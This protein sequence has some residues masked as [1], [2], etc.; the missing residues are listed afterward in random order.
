MTTTDN[1]AASDS[2]P[3]ALEDAVTTTDPVV[4]GRVWGFGGM[5]SV[6]L[7]AFA[8]FL[9]GVERLDLASAGV[10]D[11]ADGLF[12]FWSAYRVAFVLLGVLPALMALATTVVPRQCGGSLVFPRAAALAC[13]TWVVGA[14][15]T[16]VGFLVDGGLGTPGGGGER[17]ATAL[18]LMG[19]LLVICG[20][21]LAS[22]C[23]MTTIV[24]GRAAGTGLRDLPFTAW[25]TLVGAT[26]WTGM[27]P[28]LAANAVLAYVD[29]RG[30]PAVRFGAEDAIW[31]QLSWMF[32]H[33]AIY[34]LALP[35]LGIALDLVSSTTRTAQ[36]NRDV[37]LVATA[38]FGFL[39]FGAFAQTFFD[40]PGTPI[41]EEAISVVA[42]FAIVPVTLAIVG[43]L[44]DTLRRGA[45]NLGP[46]PP[47]EAVCSILAA[48]L[49]LAATVVGAVRVIAPLELLDTSVTGAHFALL[50]GAVIL[51]LGA[52]FHHWGE[53]LVGPEGRRPGMFLLGGL[54][55]AG[56]TALV[57]AADLVS[58]LM[59]Q[60][61]FTGVD[62]ATAGNPD[63]A[64]DGLNLVSM[65]G[66]FALLAG[67]A[68]WILNGSLHT[69]AN[70]KVAA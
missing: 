27:L 9:V 31:A 3:T 42:A 61:D 32:T 34:V 5:A 45:A 62:L 43:G 11:G 48:L 53:D 41:A 55:V 46:K 59:D 63:S 2:A 38:A 16:I 39:S 33:P 51:G 29:L 52:G 67:L 66:S 64:V 70:R 58:G 22:V 6:L 21:L 49:V 65:I 28:V 18:T 1:A 13:W 50:L 54:A 44:A 23:V 17:Q 24:S 10:F 56:G 57:G 15:M 69:A 8:G 12:Q 26:V 37:L 68:L 4:L 47:A 19:L 60:A 35:V 25:T 14:G 30:R 40:T 20:L 36:A 7:A